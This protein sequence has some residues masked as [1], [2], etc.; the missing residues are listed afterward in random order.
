M[1][2]FADVQ[3]QFQA[4]CLRTKAVPDLSAWASKI[5]AVQPTGAIYLLVCSSGGQ[6]GVALLQP[7]DLSWPGQ[8]NDPGFRARYFHQSRFDSNI[9]VLMDDHRNQTTVDA[10]KK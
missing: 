3:Q 7:A 1:S 6:T 2:T 5:R 10:L 8:K 9:W 4:E